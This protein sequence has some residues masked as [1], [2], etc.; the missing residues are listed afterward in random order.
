V[1][2]I[3]YFGGKSSPLERSYKGKVYD[4]KKEM[5]YAMELDL[6]QKAGE[7]R[8]WTPQVKFELEAYGKKV[9]TYTVDFKVR[10]K[11]DSAEYIEVK[12]YWTSTARLK[13]K[14]FS[15]KMAQEEPEAKLTIET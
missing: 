1:P 14:M 5:Y 11:D 6:L 4:S 8:Y 3:N 12:G 7:I 13:W 10:H 15:A 9:C 2:R